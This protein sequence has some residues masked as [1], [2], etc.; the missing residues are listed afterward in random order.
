MRTCKKISLEKSKYYFDWDNTGKFVWKN[1]HKDCRNG[2]AI[3]GQNA[4]YFTKCGYLDVHFDGN[5]CKVHRILYQLYHN[6]EIGN[7]FIDHI[8]GNRLDNRKENL[9]LSTNS[10]NC[11]N[12]KTSKR[13]ISTKAKNI[14]T[15][16]NK[17]GIEYFLIQIGKNNKR[18]R[19][20]CRV[21]KF[22]LD[23]VIKIRDAMLLEHHGE[24][25]NKG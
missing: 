15:L 6:I 3:I 16:K 24:F 8:N 21:D 7:E 22:S 19:K 18:I 23:D 17:S 13:N 12:R 20:Y 25:M 2:K 9:R 4:G 11:M 14:T 10:Q 5:Y 1:L